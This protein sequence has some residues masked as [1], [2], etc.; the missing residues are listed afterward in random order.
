M[1]DWYDEIVAGV[2]HAEDCNGFYA[3]MTIP[4]VYKKYELRSM[5]G[6][7][8]HSGCWFGSEV[9]ALHVTDSGSVGDTFPHR[10]ENRI[11][12]VHSFLSGL[13]SA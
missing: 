13:L 8:Q 3:R 12:T 5:F 1:R 4:A 2:R 9:P 10:E 6:T 7:N 11:V